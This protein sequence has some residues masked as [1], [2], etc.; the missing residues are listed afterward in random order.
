[1][2]RS[3]TAGLRARAV[4]VRRFVVVDDRL[5]VAR[6]RLPGTAASSP[7][8]RDG[9]SGRPAPT[10]PGTLPPMLLLV[11]RDPLAPRRVVPHLAGEAAAAREPGVPVALVDHDELDRPDGDAAARRVAERL[12]ELRGDDLVGG[13]VVRRSERF[14]GAE[15]RTWWVGGRCALVTAHPDTPDE[16]PEGVDAA[17]VT[18]DPVGRDAG[19]RRVVELGDGQVSDRPSSIPAADLVGAL[20]AA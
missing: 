5:V 16:R 13:L 2:G 12:R 15:A 1:M 11:P 10:A 6:R 19:V 3:G 4:V 8:A 18:V 14:T 17:F 7:P 20:V 9:V